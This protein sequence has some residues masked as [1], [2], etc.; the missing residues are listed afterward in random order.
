[1]RGWTLIKRSKAGNPAARV[2]GCF[3]VVRNTLWAYG[4]YPGVPWVGRVR[5]RSKIPKERQTKKVG[6]VAP[7]YIFKDV[8]Q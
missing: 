3:A 6:L 1:M 5:T 7:K 4:G 2:S 8:V